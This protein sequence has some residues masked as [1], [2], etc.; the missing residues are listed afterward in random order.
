MTLVL[1]GLKRTFNDYSEENRLIKLNDVVSLLEGKTIFGRFSTAWTKTF[2]GIKIPHRKQDCSDCDNEQICKR[3]NIKA[4]MIGFNC[5]RTRA[6]NSCLDL[7]SQKKTYSTDINTSKR[8]PPNEKHQSPPFYI[9]EYEPNRYKVD[10]EGAREILRKQDDKM[11]VKRRF[12]G[13]YSMM[14]CKPFMKSEDIPQNREIFIHRFK[15]IKT[16]KVGNCIILGCKSDELYEND[17]LPNFRSNK[18][19]NKEIERKDFKVTGWSF[20]TLVKKKQFF[21]A[22]RAVFVVECHVELFVIRNYCLS[23][24]LFMCVCDFRWLS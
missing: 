1:F 13:I 14:D 11:V 8:Q 16:H 18:Y 24:K 17:K 5:E 6:S 12:E 4:R 7:V 22:F 3:C 15:H 20:M 9:S 19:K 21:P 10:F 23:R 2:G